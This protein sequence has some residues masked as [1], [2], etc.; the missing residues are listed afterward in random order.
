MRGYNRVIIMG[1]LT[2]DPE[3]RYTQNQ[4][5]VASLSVACNRSVRQPDGSYKDQADFVPVTLWGKS[6]EAVQKYMSKGSGIL[7][8]GRIT[9]NSYTAK[10]GTKKY[11]TQVNGESFQFVGG[12]ADGNQQSGGQH[13]PGSQSRSGSR[14]KAAAGWGG[15]DF[16]CGPVD[17]DTLEASPQTE[18]E[19]ADIPF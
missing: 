5:A 15:Q 13:Q 19:S 4:T 14:N 2:R 9:T 17:I 6:A 8:E 16:Y 3:I 11:V 18:A 10:D 12:K 1:N 7:V